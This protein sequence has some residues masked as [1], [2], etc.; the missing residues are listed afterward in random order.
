MKMSSVF[1]LSIIVPVFYVEP[2]FR[3]LDGVVFMF[4]RE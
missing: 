3:Y 4:I 1:T 2:D